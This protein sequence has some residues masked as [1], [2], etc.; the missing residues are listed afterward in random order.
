[1]EFFEV[2]KTR[3]SVRKF[4]GAAVTPEHI[5]MMLE[6]ATY[7]PSGGN[8][9]NWRF[10]VV[11]NGAIKKKMYEALEKRIAEILAKI[12]SPTAQKQFSSYSAY[13]RFFVNAPVV[14]CAVETK[15]D[16]LSTRIL[17]RY[18]PDFEVKTYASA[19]NIAA[20]IENI[21]LSAT[22]LG[23]GSCWMTGPLIARDLFEK[24]LSIEPPDALAALVPIGVPEAVPAAPSRKPLEDVVKFL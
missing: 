8:Q 21:V 11:T 22:A 23:Y 13:Y 7:P 4:T 20:A 3:R 17:A 14:I 24:I 1:M 9:Q 5:R 19:H 16:S 12:D 15:Y 10:I 6:A 2:V 18:L